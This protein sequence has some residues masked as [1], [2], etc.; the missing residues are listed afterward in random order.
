MSL[1]E[2]HK[3]GNLMEKNRIE[4]A[5]GTVMDVK[6]KMRVIANQ[7]PNARHKAGRK[8]WQG[9]E[10]TRSFGDLYFKT[11]LP[12]VLPTPDVKVQ[13]LTSK[14]F[15]VVICSDGIFDVLSNQ[16]VVDLAAK[17]YTDP[18]E[19]SKNIVRT[20]FKKGTEDN[21]TAQVVQF[22]W[23]DSIAEKMLKGGSAAAAAAGGIGFAGVNIQ[24]DEDDM[25]M[26]G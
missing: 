15:F 21:I 6:G 16:E 8:N 24:K 9:L 13:D 26:F 10:M 1:S 4:R 5:G 12:L 7:N 23:N 14:D 18:E 17:H 2:D 22:A 20:A 19:A 11:P 25:D 3:P